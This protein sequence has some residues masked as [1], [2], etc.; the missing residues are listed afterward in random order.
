MTPAPT[1]TGLPAS[2]GLRSCSTEAK[3]G[4]RLSNLGPYVVEGDLE[5]RW[6]AL[7][8]NIRTLERLP[9]LC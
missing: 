7:S 6:R 8:L 1:A 2:L 4:D 5:E 9:D 3:K